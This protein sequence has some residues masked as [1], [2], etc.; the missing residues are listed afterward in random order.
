MIFKDPNYVDIMGAYSHITYQSVIDA[1]TA[2]VKREG[3]KRFVWGA[4]PCGERSV[5]SNNDKELTSVSFEFLRCPT[6]DRVE[7]ISANCVSFLRPDDYEVA[8][9]AN[10][11]QR[12]AYA[13]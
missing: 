7:V 1:L 6:T 11:A 2:F 13:A 9:S 3:D 8:V 4:I 12:A 5:I 10:R